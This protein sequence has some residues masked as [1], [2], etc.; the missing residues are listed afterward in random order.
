MVVTKMNTNTTTAATTANHNNDNDNVM[1][2]IIPMTMTT[3]IEAKYMASADCVATRLL[4]RRFCEPRRALR[5]ATRGNG[6]HEATTLQRPRHPHEPTGK[7][8]AKAKRPHEPTRTANLATQSSDPC[9]FA[10]ILT[11]NSNSTNIFKNDSNN[12]HNSNNYDSS[13]KNNVAMVTLKG[14]SYSNTFY[15]GA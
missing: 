12:Y 15:F 11:N 6:V 4:A 3:G 8:Y 10:L 9:C 2:T 13:L 14:Q 1:V 5:T 7:D